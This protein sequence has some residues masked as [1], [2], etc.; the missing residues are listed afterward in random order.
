MDLMRN[1]IEFEIGDCSSVQVNLH[2]YSY[3]LYMYLQLNAS[4]IRN[5]TDRL[6]RLIGVNVTFDTGHKLMKN[7]IHVHRNQS[8]VHGI[9]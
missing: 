4:L 2:S 3:V 9:T 6:N 8:I 5:L 7:K 1:L